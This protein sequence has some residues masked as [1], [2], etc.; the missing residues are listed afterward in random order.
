M[1][2]G[3]N[4]IFLV[5]TLA[6]EPELRYTST[7]VPVFEATLAG[8]DRVVGK[9]GTERFIPWYHRISMLG[10]LAQ[11]TA[12]RNLKAGE[13]LFVEGT[14]EFRQWEAEGGKRNMVSVKASRIEQLGY[15]PELVQDAGGGLR[16]HGAMNEVLI[17]GNLTRD[18]ELRV[19]KTGV[20][21]LSLPVAV[22]DRYQDRSGQWK[23]KVH[24][25]DV[26]LWH[27]LA[28]RIADL[29]IA[30][31]HPVMVTGRLVNE[32]WVDKD[33]NK[34]TN[35][36]IEA[37]RVESLTRGAATEQYGYAASSVVTP[38]AKSIATSAA[39]Q[40]RNHSGGLD[41]DDG[42]EAVQEEDFP[43]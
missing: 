21:V 7:G 6:R 39:G 36:K 43:F 31:G 35:T 18:P 3:I 41:I 25:F 14:L 33:G 12:D 9:D 19:I 37:T 26:T 17:L 16:M 24:Y 11:W 10:K 20:S 4:H 38:Q 30:K 15:E 1:A 8:E 32:S 23:D 42:L 2:R 29:G 40:N 22:N 28:E 5:G 34:R 13:S 27:E